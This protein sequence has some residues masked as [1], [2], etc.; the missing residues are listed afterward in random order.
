MAL[1]MDPRSG[2]AQ[3]EDSVQIFVSRSYGWWSAYD[4]ENPRS[5]ME[6]EDYE[7][8]DNDSI[9]YK[10]IVYNS[11]YVP[12]EMNSKLPLIAV[13]GKMTNK[14]VVFLK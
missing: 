11:E 1:E 8:S 12:S 5:S 4:E 2:T 10:D 13:T 9:I 6:Y 14:L 7:G 3:P